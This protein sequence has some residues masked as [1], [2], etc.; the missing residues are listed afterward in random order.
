MS[1]VHVKDP[2]ELGRLLL[3]D[4][5]R[6]RAEVH[7]AIV[8]AAQVATRL[9]RSRVPIDTGELRRSVHVTETAGGAEVVYDAPYAAAEEA[10]TRPFWPP[11]AP[12]LA[13]AK[14]QAP[15]LGLDEGAVY[16][17]AKAVQKKIAREGIKAK[18]FER[19]SL[20]DRRRVLARMIARAIQQ[21]KPAGAR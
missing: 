19:D 16:G 3:E 10:G 13:W 5:E 11:L 6:L 14:R 2:R 1:V 21:H 12:L 7:D 8:D 18:W 4:Q 9:I 17:F 15:N 20:P